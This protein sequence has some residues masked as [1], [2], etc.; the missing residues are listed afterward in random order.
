MVNE[1]LRAWAPRR[2]APTP[3][4]RTSHGHIETE[5]RIIP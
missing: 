1:P 5:S 3:V 4:L 2:F